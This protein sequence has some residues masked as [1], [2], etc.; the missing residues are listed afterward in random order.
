MPYYINFDKLSLQE[1]LPEKLH[2]STATIKLTTVSKAV[3]V[4]IQCQRNDDGLITELRATQ[5]QFLPSDMWSSTLCNTG[6][7]KEPPKGFTYQ[8]LVDA[9]DKMNQLMPQKAEVRLFSPPHKI[10]IGN[11]FQVRDRF[12]IQYFQINNG[13]V[14]AL[15]NVT[16]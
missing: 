14:I 15:G 4:V 12:D 9:M 6:G 16:A 10:Q 5:E 13:P 3:K 2:T 11:P 7:T 1:H 8:D